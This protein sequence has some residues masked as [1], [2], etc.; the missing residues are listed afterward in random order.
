MNKT[1][2]ATIGLEGDEDAAMKNLGEVVH[3]IDG[4]DVEPDPAHAT[5]CAVR[6][7]FD[8]D[9]WSVKMKAVLHLLAVDVVVLDEGGGRSRR[10]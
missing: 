10:R 7:F 4:V 9:R 8:E 3:V 2:S 1:H 5:A 6:V